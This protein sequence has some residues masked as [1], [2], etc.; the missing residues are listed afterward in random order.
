VRVLPSAPQLFVDDHLVERSSG[1]RRTLHRPVKDG[2]GVKPILALDD[3]Y[4]D[5]GAALE[6]NGTIVWDP[7]SSAG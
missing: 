1:I 6:A 4:G 7:A 5:L 2:G 3:E